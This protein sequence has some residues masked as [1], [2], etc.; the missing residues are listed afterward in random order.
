MEDKLDKRILHDHSDVL[1]KAPQ[2]SMTPVI[3][4]QTGNVYFLVKASYKLIREWV[5]E[6]REN[7]LPSRFTAAIRSYLED[8]NIIIHINFIEYPF[9]FETELYQDAEGK[10]KE[11]ALKLINQDH[12]YLVVILEVNDKREVIT[13]KKFNFNKSM[14]SAIYQKAK[15][16]K[17]L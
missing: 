1:N 11:Y 8:D 9:Y 14:K 17:W 10:Q 13:T 6:K 7:K 5:Q 12:F 16:E 15:A 3:S 2:D 4:E